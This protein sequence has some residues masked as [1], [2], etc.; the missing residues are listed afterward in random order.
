ME[1]LGKDR[2]GRIV[3]H[4]ASI[5]ERWCNAGLAWRIESGYKT[6][7]DSGDYL[8]IAFKTP[9]TGQVY[10]N[11]ATVDKSGNELVKSLI[12][13]PA[14]SGGSVTVAQNFDDNIDGALCPVTDILVGLSTDTTPCTITGGTELFVSLVPGTAQGNSKPGGSSQ[15]QGVIKL[16][17]NTVYALKVLA[18]GAATLAANIGFAYIPEE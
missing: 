12:R 14:I 15:L 3:D 4:S 8:T 6:L 10:Y 2:N 7:A 13:A 9:E 18:K 1:T 11:F 16:R 17:K 5:T